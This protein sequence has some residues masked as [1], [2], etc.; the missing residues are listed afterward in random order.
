MVSNRALRQLADDARIRD[1]NSYGYDPVIYNQ[2]DLDDPYEDGFMFDRIQVD[3]LLDELHR[4]YD[5]SK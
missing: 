1:F 2:F 3:R 4:L 5:L